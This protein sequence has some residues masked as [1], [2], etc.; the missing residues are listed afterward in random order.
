MLWTPSAWLGVSSMDTFIYARDHDAGPGSWCV[1][2]PNGF[3]VVCNEKNCAYILGKM[4]SGRFL[5][6]E[7]MARDFT[8][9][10]TRT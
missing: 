8:A 6:A 5:E 1:V 4:L 9:M 2:G 3:K 10:I 7:R